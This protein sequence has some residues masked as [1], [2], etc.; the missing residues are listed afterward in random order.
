MKLYI[1]N[2]VCHCCKTVVK[3]ELEKLGLN[4]IALNL[5]EVEIIEEI[6]TAQ[7]KEFKAALL[8]SGLELMDDKKNILIE[9]IKIVILISINHSIKPSYVNFSEH[10]S[11]QIEYD[12]T[13]LANL[14]SQFE[15]TT[16]ERYVIIHK[17]ERVKE[18][19]IYDEL[20]LKEISYQMGYSSVAHLPN[21][22][23]KITNLTT[24]QFKN[25]KNYNRTT[26][27]RL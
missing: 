8:Q 10:L 20:S 6:S 14:F 15:G 9:R 18:L 22:F 4:L 13:Y 26:P 25:L 7:E 12:Y 2:M 24:S 23:K 5:G 19:L 11:K 17:I 27:C 1:K 16:I 21:Q 3:Q